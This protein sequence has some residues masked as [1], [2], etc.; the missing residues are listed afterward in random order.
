MSCM[1]A[2]YQNLKNPGIQADFGIRHRQAD[3]C[4]GS[5]PI[6]SHDGKSY[7]W[8]PAGMADFERTQVGASEAIPALDQLPCLI[9]DR[10]PEV[11]K[12]R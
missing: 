10:A 7:D 1:P 4:A 11:L 2:S 6:P 8:L 9:V 3:P 5:V 12:V